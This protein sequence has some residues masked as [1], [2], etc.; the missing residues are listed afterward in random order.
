VAL[1]Q[2]APQQLGEQLLAPPPVLPPA[3]PPR[4]AQPP[5]A[6][7]LPAQPVGL[8]QVLA[9]RELLQRGLVVVSAVAMVVG[10]C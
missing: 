1:P 3:L 10:G 4:L 2:Q 7:A 6:R 5:L 9:V 8:A